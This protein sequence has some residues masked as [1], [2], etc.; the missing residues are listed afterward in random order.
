[1]CLDLHIHIWFR[2]LKRTLQCSHILLSSRYICNILWLWTC[3]CSHY[4][5]NKHKTCYNTTD[6]MDCGECMLQ[7]TWGIIFLWLGLFWA[8]WFAARGISWSGLLYVCFGSLNKEFSKLHL[9]SVW[10]GGGYRFLYLYIARLGA[11]YGQAW[12]CTGARCSC[13][14]GRH[15]SDKPM[16]V[17]VGL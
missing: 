4:N 15:V 2:E 8:L 12:R 7:L 11:E 13:C 14:W 6:D 17:A 16:G 3:V 5:I 10:G 9:I 1:M